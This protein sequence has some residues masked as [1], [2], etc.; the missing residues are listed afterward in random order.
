[1]LCPGRGL[2]SRGKRLEE[3]L[4]QAEGKA[5]ALGEQLQVSAA[6]VDR[7]TRARKAL[8]AEIESAKERDAF[9]ESTRTH[10]QTVQTVLGVVPTAQTSDAGRGHRA[11]ASWKQSCA[12]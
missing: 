3:L 1:L 12:G 4:K 10:L 11:S 6:E 8:E 2:S 9:N 5:A 7:L